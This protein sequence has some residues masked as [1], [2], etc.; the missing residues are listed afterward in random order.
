MTGF[1]KT[2]YLEW[3][4]AAVANPLRG[5]YNSLEIAHTCYLV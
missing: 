5:E 3:P 2:E 1:E 4:R